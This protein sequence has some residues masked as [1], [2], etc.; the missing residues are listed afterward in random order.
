[1]EKFFFILLFISCFFF[2]PV[3][4]QVLERVIVDDH[5]KDIDLSINSA[6]TFENDIIVLGRLNKK[7]REPMIRRITTNGDVVWRTSG[8]DTTAYDYTGLRA[9]RAILGVDSFL[10]ASVRAMHGA[11]NFAYLWKLDPRTGQLIWEILLPS[12]DYGALHIKELGT[13]RLVINLENLGSS[14]IVILDKTTG[15]VLK[16]IELGAWSHPALEADAAANI[17]FCRNDSLYK[18]GS[19]DNYS[20]PVWATALNNGGSYLIQD[21]DHIVFDTLNHQILVFGR[22]DWSLGYAAVAAVDIETGQQNW[23]MYLQP[24]AELAYVDHVIDGQYCYLALRNI[25]SGGG[26]YYFYTY[27]I[28]MESGNLEWGSNE[29]LFGTTYSQDAN[30][31]AIDSAGN[32]YLGG[33]SYGV[34]AGGRWALIKLDG[35]T[36]TKMYEK[37]YSLFD[38][39]VHEHEG[40]IACFLRLDEKL[41]SLS[42]MT[43]HATPDVGL[44]GNWQI[45]LNELSLETGEVLSEVFIGEQYSP[46]ATKLIDMQARDNH[47]QFAALFKI[48][49]NVELRLYESNGSLVWKRKIELTNGIQEIQGH[50][51]ELTPDDAIVISVQTSDDIFYL[52]YNIDGDFVHYAEVYNNNDAIPIQTLTNGDKTWA[53]LQG[54]SFSGVQVDHFDLQE[55][56]STRDDIDFVN[57]LSGAYVG[58]LDNDSLLLIHDRTT[59]FIDD[60]DFGYRLGGLYPRYVRAVE[61]I[62]DDILLL[63]GYEMGPFTL[64]A[65]TPSSFLY[66]K[67]ENAVISSIS[68]SVVAQVKKHYSHIAVGLGTAYTYYVE[69]DENDFNILS[70]RLVQRQGTGTKNWSIELGQ[71]F[72]ALCRVED[73]A[74]NEIRNEIVVLSKLSREASGTQFRDILVEVFDPD[75]NRIAYYYREGDASSEEVEA[76]RVIVMPDGSVHIGVNMIIDGVSVIDGATVAVLTSLDSDFY[77]YRY[78]GTVYYDLNQDGIKADTEPGV[79]L[80]TISIASQDIAYIL[81]D[82]TYNVVLPEGTSSLDFQL[83]EHWTLT[84]E[85]ASYLLSA[86]IDPPTDSLNFGIFPDSLYT[87]ID[88]NISSSIL[89]CN[90]RAM[91]LMTVANEGTSVENVHLIANLPDNIHSIIASNALMPDSIVGNTYHFTINSLQPGSHKEIRFEFSVPG[92]SS[93]NELLSF[94]MELSSLDEDNE[95]HYTHTFQDV[96]RCSYDPNDKL[97]QPLG[98][99]EEGYTLFDVEELTYTI[100]FQNTGNDYAYKVRLVDTLDINLDVQTLVVTQSSHPLSQVVRRGNI[101]EF[102]FDPIALA[103]E[104][105]DDLGSQGFVSFKIKRLDDLDENTIISNAAAIYFDSNPPIYTNRVVNT[106]VSEIPVSVVEEKQ[107]LDV[108]LIP[109]PFTDSFMFGFD[110]TAVPLPWI[111]QIWNNNGQLMKQCT[112]EHITDRIQM[113]TYS[114][115][116]YWISINTPTGRPLAVLKAIKI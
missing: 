71:G 82:G 74:F 57:S 33:Y 15:S 46:L 22:T 79:E 16:T 50:T 66:S 109:N 69:Q 17:Y 13:D 23:Y 107:D 65:H 43:W 45:V 5:L 52:R 100:R 51:L 32:I 75:G 21:T 58:R 6:F 93:I 88:L 64:N 98:L 56:E 47:N 90:E 40:F 111:A 113:S 30:D 14:D 102:I 85:H 63:A 8:R 110:K 35:D 114:S 11:G 28:D 12:S 10:Y 92:V 38:P 104:S 97:V 49:K 55:N 72:Q 116:I 24:N 44:P 94:E 105:L 60:D 87:S 29:G 96:I 18:L 86:G 99:Y 48:G 67:T 77:N 59:Y 70:D 89:R 25:L 76:K 42:K 41:Y 103:Y 78:G 73:I 7:N 80:G 20:T 2:T 91:A 61:E 83:P 112:I 19:S 95:Y 9:S 26:N 34:V 53:F 106:F 54:G 115:G 31:I 39:T 37:Q 84:S 101:V 81:D 3:F 4:G 36:G 62:N 68:D 108:I 27:K 1:M